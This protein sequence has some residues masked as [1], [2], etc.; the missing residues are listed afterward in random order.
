MQSVPPAPAVLP[1]KV[2][3]LLP[4]IRNSDSESSLEEDVEEEEEGEILESEG[5]TSE[6]KD[7][8]EVKT[9]Q[10]AVEEEKIQTQTDE[11]VTK[12]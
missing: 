3:Q 2:K 10:Q 7:S 8:M 11:A 4:K 5:Q 6:N 9:Q 12:M 1:A